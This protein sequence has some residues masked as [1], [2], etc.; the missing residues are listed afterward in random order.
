MHRQNICVDKIC[1][2]T[3]HRRQQNICSDKIYA[4]T[5]RKRVEL[6]AGLLRSNHLLER[7]PRG[8]FLLCATSCSPGSRSPPVL[9]LETPRSGLTAAL[10]NF[11][12][13]PRPLLLACAASG[14]PSGPSLLVRSSFFS[15]VPMGPSAAS[16]RSASSSRRPVFLASSPCPVTALAV[17]DPARCLPCH[18]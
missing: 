16:R 11:L 17:P 12:G 13:R 2:S 8:L 5:K 14:A 9:P 15:S 6:A 1:A 3:K 4:S 10:G 18:P 7:S